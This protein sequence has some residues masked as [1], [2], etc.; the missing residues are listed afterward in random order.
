[1]RKRR[2]AAYLKE[3]RERV[4]QQETYLPIEARH[5]LIGNVDRLRD[6]EGVY[7]NQVTY[8][9]SIKPS[10]D[11]DFV[12]D[13]TTS[14]V[15]RIVGRLPNEFHVRM[16]KDWLNAG[17]KY[18]TE[19]RKEPVPIKKFGSETTTFEKLKRLGVKRLSEAH[20]FTEAMNLV[21]R[22]LNN[23]KP[24]NGQVVWL[25][26]VKKAKDDFDAYISETPFSYV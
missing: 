1:M 2:L 7:Q 6:S 25:H 13:L 19:H 5:P 4:A 3:Q 17:R 12:A 26:A 22:E 15:H 18:F 11:V 20:A 16:F 23:Y 10:L 21:M 14:F 8:E 9:P 24:Y